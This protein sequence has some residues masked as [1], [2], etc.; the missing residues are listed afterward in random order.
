MGLTVYHHLISVLV[1]C[2]RQ[3]GGYC[4]DALNFSP[5]HTIFFDCRH[6][7]DA[8]DPIM[9]IHDRTLPL[10]CRH[11]S[12]STLGTMLGYLCFLV[13]QLNNYCL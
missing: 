4:D 7:V 5:H 11:R 9:L 10:S 1:P 3:R 6:A 2:L 13:S 12:V 8:H